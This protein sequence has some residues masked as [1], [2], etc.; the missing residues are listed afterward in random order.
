[1][2]YSSDLFASNA[3][4]LQVLFEEKRR[5]FAN[6]L[7]NIQKLRSTVHEVV[8]Q[9]LR[10]RQSWAFKKHIEKRKCKFRN[11]I[12]FSLKRKL[13]FH[14]QKFLSLKRK[15]EFRNPNLK[16]LKRNCKFCNQNLKRFKM[17]TQIPQPKIENS[18]AQLQLIA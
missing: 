2:V 18:T 9:L 6:I 8:S 5:F 15:C 12:F 3:K 14:N 7:P 17:L 16:S 11:Q 13:K 1:M 4:Y 10:S